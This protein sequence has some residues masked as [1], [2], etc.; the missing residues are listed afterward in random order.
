M[1][2]DVSFREL[3]IE[4]PFLWLVNLQHWVVLGHR[5]KKKR[6]LQVQNSCRRFLTSSANRTQVECS[7]KRKMA[8]GTIT[9]TS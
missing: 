9:H 2:H 6:V 4:F 3:E 5:V 1:L 7:E 8:T